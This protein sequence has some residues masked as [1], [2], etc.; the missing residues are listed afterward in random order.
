MMENSLNNEWLDEIRQRMQEV[1]NQAKRDK[2]RDEYGMQ[3]WYTDSNLPPETENGWLDYLLEFER[4]FEEA[5][6]ITVRERI[7]NPPFQPLSE[8]PLYSVE[9]AVTA[10]LDLLAVHGIAVDFLGEV[11]D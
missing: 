5:K 9:E 8:L 10:L 7:G 1:L 2:L 3:S 4:Q 6:S 11:D